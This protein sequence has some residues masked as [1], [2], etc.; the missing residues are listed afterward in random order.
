MK[1][2]PGLVELHKKF[3][4]DVAAVTLSFDYQSKDDSHDEKSAEALA[5]LKKINATFDNV[6]TKE[7]S[8]EVMAAM[9]IPTIPAVLVY[10]RD[11]KLAKKFA[12]EDGEF[13]YDDVDQK[14]AELIATDGK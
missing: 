4:R 8:D 5:V 11:G 3:P 10:A 14:V 13:T 6:L 7:P 2:L 12:S 1:E 9:K